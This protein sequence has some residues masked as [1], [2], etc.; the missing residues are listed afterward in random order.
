MSPVHFADGRKPV[1]GDGAGHLILK[2]WSLSC[3]T[4]TAIAHPAAGPAGNLGQFIGRKGPHSPT[5]KLAERRECHVIDIKVQPHANRIGGHQIIHLAVL[6]H[7]NLRIAGTRRQ[8]PHHHRST[9]FLA[10]D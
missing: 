7:R 8:R 6:I 5:V 4:E 10:P 3:N 2:R 1:S 9:A